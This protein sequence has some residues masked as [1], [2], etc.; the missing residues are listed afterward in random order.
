MAFI[1]TSLIEQLMVKL[2][3][4]YNFY[5]NG[6]APNYFKGLVE[7]EGGVKVSGGQVDLTENSGEITFGDNPYNQPDCLTIKGGN[8][9][10]W[11]SINNTGFRV[12]GSNTKAGQAYGGVYASTVYSANNTSGTA[13]LERCDYSGVTDKSLSF[14]GFNARP[15]NLTFGVGDTGGYRAFSAVTPA[16][17]GV[18]NFYGASDSP[19]FF[20]GDTHI[21][22]DTSSNTFELWKSTLTEEQL[23]QLEAGTLVAPANVSTPGDGS[24]ARA[25]YYDQQDE[26]TQLALDSGELEYPTHLAAATFTDTF[27]LGDQT[28]INLLSSGGIQAKSIEFTGQGSANRFNYRGIGF[29]GSNNTLDINNHPNNADENVIVIQSKAHL[30]D[31]EKNN[32]NAGNL[33][34]FRARTHTSLDRTLFTGATGLAID[35]LGRGS[36]S[37]EAGWSGDSNVYGIYSNIADR[38]VDGK[39]G[40]TYNFYATGD[41]PNYFKG[42]TYVGGLTEA[43]KVLT[44]KDV[45]SISEFGVVPNSPDYQHEAIQAAIDAVDTSNG[46]VTINF[47]D[48]S[49]KINSNIRISKS[50][51][52]INLGNAR[53]LVGDGIYD[54]EKPYINNSEFDGGR[55]QAAFEFVASNASEIS[56]RNPTGKGF[57]RGSNQID[58]S[59][60]S[61]WGK[62][63]LIELISDQIFYGTTKK[64][65]LYEVVHK[66]TG[67]GG[68]NT[69]AILD[70]GADIDFPTWTL[71]GD[72]TQARAIQP[73][74]HCS[75]TGGTF[76]WEGKLWGDEG[77]ADGLT[78]GFGPVGVR[79]EGT[80]DFKI[81]GTKFHHFQNK[82]LSV[83]RSLRPVIKDCYFR[84][85]PSTYNGDDLTGST[86]QSTG[87]YALFIDRCY[88]PL[89]DNIY[90]DRVRH[91]IDGSNTFK[92]TVSNCYG[93][94]NHSSTYRAH[95][96]CVDY[97]FS[98]CVA[99][100]GKHYAVGWSGGNVT[101]TGCHFTSNNY[102]IQIDYGGTP[103]NQDVTFDFNVVSST[104]N[105]SEDLYAESAASSRCIYAQQGYYAI[106]VQG[107][108]LLQ[109]PI[110]DSEKDPNGQPGRHIQISNEKIDGLNICDNHFYYGSGIQIID[111]G[112]DHDKV[113]IR[114]NYFNE[115][116]TGTPG[117]IN[118]F[119]VQYTN[120]GTPRSLQISV[121]NNKFK[122]DSEPLIYT[123]GSNDPGQLIRDAASVTVLNNTI[124]D[125]L[126]LFQTPRDNDSVD[127]KT[128]V[129]SGDLE[130]TGT[131]NGDSALLNS[132]ISRLDA[133]ESN[134]LVDDATDSALLTLIANL[135]SRLTTLEESIN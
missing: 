43:D 8:G 12:W 55:N 127:D 83:Q 22:G 97:T 99:A 10:N 21:G 71:N 38:T 57:K 111:C 29:S 96:G 73:I 87:W 39:P 56:L 46:P 32:V 48:G 114:D 11:I 75:L 28:K 92:G 86:A 115:T 121:L 30:V 2:E 110:S 107:C 133:L 45:Y 13:F 41:A 104:I 125:G 106:T 37:T 49:Y 129:I 58:F 85:L 68:T 64:F 44:Q 79:I 19:N 117:R 1:A 7:S 100:N 126:T 93:S 78:N 61:G 6:T 70:H 54:P 50:D 80:V 62:N 88:A 108:Q 40:K 67:A 128:L 33:T 118:P 119:V 124:G 31:D 89:M 94:Y 76:E 72:E 20:A 98:N 3:K 25:W 24:F 52:N 65:G 34:S 82:G 116:Q 123:T 4:T 91:T 74:R 77:E 102:G 60:S 130:V 109:V 132:T 59:T 42:D 14:Y 17:P 112:K 26:E 122:A 35:N 95:S 69:L 9:S 103:R 23:E 18:F 81:Q 113:V 16:L 63:Y 51:I 134:E 90:G 101:F 120:T 5:A 53:I 36:N 27:E 135:S 15:N 131:I 66:T 84:G 47:P 105:V